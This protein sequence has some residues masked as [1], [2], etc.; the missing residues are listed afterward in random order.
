MVHGGQAVVEFE[1][2]SGGLERND[3]TAC[4]ALRG[5]SGAGVAAAPAPLLG[6][7]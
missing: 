2:T 5:V 7:C 1:L 4:A 6:S 3:E